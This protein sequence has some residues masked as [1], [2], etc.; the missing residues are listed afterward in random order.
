MDF[1]HHLHPFCKRPP[2]GFLPFLIEGKV[3]GAIRRDLA[4]AL[5]PWPELFERPGDRVALA[6]DLADP[7]SRSAALAPVVEQLHREGVIPT[8]VGEPFPLVRRFGEEPAALVERAAIHFFGSR[9][10]GVHVNGLVRGARGVEVWLARRSLDNPL[11]PGKFDQLVAGGVAFGYTP[12]E[13]LVKEAEEEAAIP[14]A[15]ARE[16]R[17]AGE[18]SYLQPLPWGLEFGTLLVY[19][20]WLPE[21]F[22][23]RNLDGEVAGFERI[24]IASLK[25]LLEEEG[26]FKPNVALVY[27]DLLLRLGELQGDPE[28]R[29]GLYGEVSL[30]G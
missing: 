27:L 30:E 8:W 28:L 1:H 2:E 6:R 10:F 13:T 12:E 14:E 3:Y 4:E 21:D 15:L 26:L 17:F 29:E 5:D 25:A 24:P 20:L 22:T 23:P 19:D 18:I 7:P 16:A 9:A 11:W